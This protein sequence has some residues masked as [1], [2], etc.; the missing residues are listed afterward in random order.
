MNK[1][2]IFVPRAVVPEA[3]E[4]LRTRCHVEVGPEGGLP[5]EELVAAVRGY[6][7]IFT[8][9]IGLNADVIDAWKKLYNA[10]QDEQT[11]EAIK[12]IIEGLKA[13]D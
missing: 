7:G 4:L 3:V 2:R 5:H 6:D 8:P 11:R 12:L 13:R 10:T 1:P 9:V